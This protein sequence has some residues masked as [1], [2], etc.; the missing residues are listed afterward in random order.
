AFPFNFLLFGLE[1]LLFL[2]FPARMLAN[3][4]GDFQA[5]GRN[6]LFTMAK[7]M[8]IVLVALVAGLSGVVV[9]FLVGG[10]SVPG[11]AAA[12]VVVA[13]C[14]AGLVPAVALA[15]RNFDVGR[16]TPP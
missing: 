14:D 16:D 15:F 4:P 6:V 12:W 8:G 3:T 9:S 2:L 7:L 13:C 5:V 1:N 11:V 10:N